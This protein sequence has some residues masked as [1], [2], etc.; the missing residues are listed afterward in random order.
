MI[1]GLNIYE[2]VTRA[3]R[4]SVQPIY[5]SDQSDPDEGTYVWAYVVNV[6]NEGDVPVQLMRRTWN[7]VDQNGVSRVVK[8][9]GVVGEQPLIAPG[10]CYE[11]TSGTPLPTPSGMMAGSYEMETAEGGVFEVR[12][13][14]FSLDCPE[15]GRVLN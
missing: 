12:I 6:Q 1:D 5:L 10:D 14:T 13:P 4:V 7:I 3:I 15:V 8:G 11:Y 9:I 2:E